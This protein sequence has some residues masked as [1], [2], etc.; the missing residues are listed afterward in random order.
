MMAPTQ[1]RSLSPSLR[2]ELVIPFL[3]SRS[4]NHGKD[5]NRSP[6]Y[7][8]ADQR[9][10]G[11]ADDS[12]LDRSGSRVDRRY[13]SLCE[14]SGKTLDSQTLL[15]QRFAHS[16]SWRLANEHGDSTRLIADHTSYTNA[17]TRLP[18]TLVLPRGPRRD[19]RAPNAIF[20]PAASL[21]TFCPC[22]ALSHY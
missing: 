11:T 19:K 13:R 8:A 4:D 6:S 12:D 20:S 15:P 21:E 17:N 9:R 16:Y 1:R 5:G 14:R 22:D 2:K 3:R 18:S 7:R 10:A